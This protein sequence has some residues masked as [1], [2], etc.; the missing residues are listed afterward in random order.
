MQQVSDAGGSFAMVSLSVLPNADVL[1]WRG[2]VA[3]AHEIGVPVEELD[4]G[5]VTRD[6]ASERVAEKYF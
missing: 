5:D 3:E 2:T 1:A 4:S 6:A